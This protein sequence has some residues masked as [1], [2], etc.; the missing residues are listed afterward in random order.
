MKT[1]GQ[2]DEGDE[3]EWHLLHKLL[4]STKLSGRG[5][6]I[7][8]QIISDNVPTKEWM[9]RK[10]FPVEPNCECG[11]CDTLNHRLEGCLLH[12]TN[13]DGQ[14][15]RQLVKDELKFN[16]RPLPDRKSD[17]STSRMGYPSDL[18]T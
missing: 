10:G 13:E 2:M 7:A 14:T 16:I 3:I 4:K 17:M 15:S 1:K 12:P 9:N 5:K 11:D 8:M 18:K 6:G